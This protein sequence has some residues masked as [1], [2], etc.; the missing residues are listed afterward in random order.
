M[1]SGSN[2]V[3]GGLSIHAQFCADDL[4]RQPLSA[5][6]LPLILASASPRRSELL[7]QAGICFEVITTQL[8]EP[9]RKPRGVSVRAWAMALAYFKAAAVAQIHRG[10]WVLGADTIVVVD[11]QLLNKAA[12]VHEARQMLRKQVGRESQVL[13]GVATLRIE[14][15]PNAEGAAQRS[16]LSASTIGASTERHLRCALTRVWMKPDYE[17]ME[18]Y[19]AT[20]DWQ[21][22]AGAYG[23]QDV[24]DKLVERIDGSFSNVVGLPVEVVA[25]LRNIWG[26]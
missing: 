8:P 22:K 1:R 24:G 11:D 10:R 9:E 16:W 23:I 13:T 21:G 17:E 3:L 18:R 19:L 5:G 14:H 4:S 15:A 2:R 7:A 6:Q 12:D 20:G 25:S 26:F